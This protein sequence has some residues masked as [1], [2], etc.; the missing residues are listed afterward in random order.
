MAA[1]LEMVAVVAMAQNRVIGD[2]SNLLWHL[3]ADLKRVKALTMGCPLIMGRRTWD[4]IGRALPGRASIVMTR[5]ASWTGEGALRAAS[6]DEAV[7]LAR[8]WIAETDGARPEI[9][10]FGG[11]EIYAAGLALTNRIELTVIG[12]DVDGGAA[13]AL[14]PELDPAA[15]DRQVLEEVPGDGDVPAHRYESLTRKVPVLV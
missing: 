7:R 5:D 11:G 9:I 10:L 15:W 3:P 6:M 14:F 4:S 1:G 13:A 8:G 12:I 2:G